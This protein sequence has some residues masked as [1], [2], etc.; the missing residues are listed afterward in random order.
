MLTCIHWNATARNRMGMPS[1]V[2]RS[3]KASHKV[4]RHAPARPSPSS[5]LARRETVA[6]ESL[7][8]TRVS[9]SSVTLHLRI[10]AAGRR[11][12][13]AQDRR[14]NILPIAEKSHPMLEIGRLSAL[15]NGFTIAGISRRYPAVNLAHNVEGRLESTRGEQ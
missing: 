2:A 4:T 14:L 1:P 3:L 12:L 9:S 13:R 8:R 5:P 11:R 15:Q 10:H 7:P 6:T